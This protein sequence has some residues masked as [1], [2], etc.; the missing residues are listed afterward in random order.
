VLIPED[1]TL[2]P[3][4]ISRDDGWAIDTWITIE[5]RSI[6]ERPDV[7]VIDDGRG[8]MLRHV[9]GRYL[10]GCRNFTYEQAVAHW[11]NPDHEAPASAAILLAAVEAHHVGTVAE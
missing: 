3:V 10:A 8:Y 7:L 4:V 11:S 5:G 9:E 6:V 2:S 1:Q